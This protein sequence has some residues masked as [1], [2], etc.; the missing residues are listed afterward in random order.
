MGLNMQIIQVH[1]DTLDIT[2]AMPVLNEFGVVVGEKNVRSRAVDDGV[3]DSL[4]EDIKKNGLMNPVTVRA[5]G[6]TWRLVAGLHRTTAFKKMGRAT[7]PATVWVPQSSNPTIALYQEVQAELAE[8]LVRNDRGLEEMSARM[9]S[10]ISGELHQ[11]A[12]AK[13]VAKMEALEAEKAALTASIAAS[14]AEATRLE[15]LADEAATAAKAKA[16]TAVREDLVKQAVA[17]KARG[18][19]I[20]Q[21]ALPNAKQ[22]V[23]R[24]EVQIGVAC[25]LSDK[26]DSLQAKSDKPQL[27]KGALALA[28]EKSGTSEGVMK[29]RNG[30]VTKFGVEVV[31]MAA[32]IPLGR[33]AA[34]T[35]LSDVDWRELGHLK[36]QFP[37][38]YA[39]V[40]TSWEKGL[41]QIEKWKAMGSPMRT[42]EAL[43]PN[44][45]LKKCRKDDNDATREEARKTRLGALTY[46]TE[47][48]GP[49]TV[50]VAKALEAIKLLTPDDRNKL[51][52]D[53]DGAYERLVAVL[54]RL[55]ALKREA[56][57][58]V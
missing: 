26:S 3:V 19:E 58:T 40:V 14:R 35:G 27:A 46:A 25:K 24:A 42:V 57:G 32:L 49:A 44:S 21:R 36:D 55:T 50:Q 5:V 30:R 56:K 53:V 12:H 4:V 17:D 15:K 52:K 1:L 29:V 51:Q 33:D 28:A 23:V 31:R 13:A 10:A 43:D 6:E 7:I 54:G 47:K 39:R 41:A 20:S 37:A 22:D 45:V 34:R 2:G 9:L 8:N 38:D 18:R 16:I 11:V 48:L